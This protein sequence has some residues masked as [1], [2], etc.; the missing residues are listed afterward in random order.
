MKIPFIA[1]RLGTGLALLALVAVAPASAVDNSYTSPANDA[2]AAARSRIAE[3]N[4]PAAVNELKR[5]DARSSADWNNLLGYSLRKSGPAHFAEASTYYNEAL[6]I[7]PKHRGALEYSGELFLMTGDLAAAEQRL[8][9]LD[10]AC[11]LPCKEHRDLKSAIARF[12]VN[13]NRYVAE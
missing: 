10:K 2:L 5:V 12:K 4:W 8:A 7:E 1:R 3:K 13:G 6:R 9:V 11:F